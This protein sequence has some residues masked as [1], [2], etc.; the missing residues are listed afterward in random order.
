MNGSPAEHPAQ[1]DQRLVGAAAARLRIDAADLD[2]VAI[3]AADADAE[4]QAPGRR[5][6]ERRE[7]ARNRHGMPQR[8]QIHADLH[9]QSVGWLA[10]SVAACTTPSMP[11][12]RVEA[13]VVGDEHV[14][15]P[16][17][18]D[19]REQR[20]PA[21]QRAAQHLLVCERTQPELVCCGHRVDSPLPER[22]AAYHRRASR[23]PRRAG[24]RA[25]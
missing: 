2:L 21:L 11:R 15:E 17:V 12:P 3:L 23:F 10:S 16:G 18:G 22:G 24:A 13:H 19:T 1:R 8:E 6:G 4:H 5:F 25:R 20:A 14:I 7:L 9:A